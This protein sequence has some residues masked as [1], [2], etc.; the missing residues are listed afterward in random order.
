MGCQT[1][2]RS[3]VLDLLGVSL[4]DYYNLVDVYL[5]AVL[6]PNCIKDPGTFAQEGWHHEL[7]DTKV[8]SRLLAN[9]IRALH[10]EH[11]SAWICSGQA[12]LLCCGPAQGHHSILAGRQ[13]LPTG[14][15]WPQWL[16][17]H[18]WQHPDRMPAAF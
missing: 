14:S 8:S 16:A 4:Q 3:R 12:R 18:P 15:S 1:C 9:V 2:R 11:P 10:C 7:E 6:H 13:V 17:P 5:D